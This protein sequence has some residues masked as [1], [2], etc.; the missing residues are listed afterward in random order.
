LRQLAKSVT[1][2]ALLKAVVGLIEELETRAR[3]LEEAPS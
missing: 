2:K 1:D 3:E